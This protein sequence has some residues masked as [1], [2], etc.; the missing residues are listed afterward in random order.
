MLKNQ[1]LP[2]EFPGVS[3]SIDAEMIR[4]QSEQPLHILSSAVGPHATINMIFLIDAHLTPA[5]MV[6]AVITVTEAKTDVLLPRSV[7]TPEGHRATG[8]STDAIVVAC[9][10]RGEPLPYAGPATEVG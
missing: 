2:L 7:L 6:N 3:A 1:P 10:N 4:L 5:A 9:T 8:T